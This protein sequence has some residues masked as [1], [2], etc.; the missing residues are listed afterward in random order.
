[1]ITG[2][3]FLLPVVLLVVGPVALV[4]WAVWRSVRRRSAREESGEEA[5]DAG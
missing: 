3:L 1:M 5:S 2:V 4:A